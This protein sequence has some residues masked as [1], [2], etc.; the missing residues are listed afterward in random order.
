VGEVSKGV[1]VVQDPDDASESTVIAIRS[2]ARELEPVSVPEKPLDVVFHALVSMVVARR[3]ASLDEALETFRRAYPFRHLDREDLLRV[4]DFAQSLER[5]FLR[6]SEDGRTFGRS[7]KT[8]RA[9]EYYFGNLSMIPEFRQYLVVDDERNQPVGILDE[10]FVAEYG[11]PGVKF[12]M[13][14][15]LWRIVQVFRNKVFVKSDEDPIGAIPTWIGEEI[16]VP[17]SVAQEV[18]VMRAE[19]EKRL[20]EGEKFEEAVVEFASAYGVGRETIERAVAGVRKQLE[21]GLVVPTHGLVTVERV[22]DMCIVNACFGTLVN[23]T[24]ARLLAYKISAELGISV[25]TSID[26]YRIILRSESLD[27]ETVLQIL[28]GELSKDLKRDLR[29]IIEESRFFKWR[30]AQVARRMGVLEREVELTSSILEKLARA[31]RGTPAFEETF[32]EVV[33]KDLDLERTLKVLEGLKCGKIG[34]ISLGER[35]EPTP[36]SLPVFRRRYLVLEPP[37]YGRAKILAVASAK[38]RLLSET[39]TLACMGCRSHVEEKKV[40]DLRERPE[41]PRCG[42][43]ELGA[44]EESEEE[45][46][47]ALELFERGRKTPLWRKLSQSSKLVFKFGKPA[48]VVFAGRGITP[49]AAREI[50]ARAPKLSDRLLEFVLRKEREALF[51]RFGQA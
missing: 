51:R 41:C 9:F 16:P 46:R 50:L 42:S 28:R 23:R 29:Q 47:R 12:V 44:V 45:V 5:R 6:L 32:K 8:E 18:G 37:V 13:A 39:L 31:L 30:L 22:K 14:G 15:S 33:T 20:R 35:E 34:V 24:L 11:K 43:R 10:S 2:R 40:Y 38:A 48:V 19:F 27:P 3:E 36:L 26:P 25:A 17:F 4:L 1:I 49:A 7:G 21:A